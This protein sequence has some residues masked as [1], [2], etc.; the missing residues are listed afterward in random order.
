MALVHD[1]YALRL[2]DARQG[3]MRGPELHVELRDR[4]LDAEEARELRDHLTDWLQRVGRN[5]P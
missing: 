5:E 4:E 1:G 2:A 3:Q